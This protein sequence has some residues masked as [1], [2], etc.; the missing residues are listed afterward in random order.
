MVDWIRFI[1]DNKYKA[2][3][4]CFGKLV[5]HNKV[6]KIGS[7]AFANYKGFEGE[8]LI[9]NSVTYI[10]NCYGF[11]KLILPDFIGYIYNEGTLV[12][13]NRTKYLRKRAFYNC[14]GFDKLVINNQKASFDDQAFASTRLSLVSFNELNE[15][16][17]RSEVF[18]SNQKIEV[19][20]GYKNKEFCKK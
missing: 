14:T 5:I 20:S 11:S 19:P 9:P 3:T 4:Q 8:L 12:I 17:C 10:A 13:S 7:Y 6:T 16:I 18:P 15:F 1:P 2:C